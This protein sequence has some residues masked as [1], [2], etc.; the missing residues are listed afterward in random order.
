MKKIFFILSVVM[1]SCRSNQKKFQLNH[2]DRIEVFYNNPSFRHTE[3]NREIIDAFT[4]VLKEKPTKT[5]CEKTGSIWLMEG[6][7]IRLKLD[8][9]VTG[10]GCRFLIFKDEDKRL[11][12]RLN[13]RAG[14]YLGEYLPQLMTRQHVEHH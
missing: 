2:I 5:S 12:Y 8:F 9:S 4:T 11:G 6:H 7:I 13:D 3:L 14:M 10:P 1:I